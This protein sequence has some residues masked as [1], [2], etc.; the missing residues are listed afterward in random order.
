MTPAL[1]HLLGGVLRDDYIARRVR[2]TVLSKTLNRM[3]TIRH[4]IL[5]EQILLYGSPDS[6]VF[7][8]TPMTVN[9]YPEKGWVKHTKTSEDWRFIGGVRL[10]PWVAEKDSYLK[11]RRGEQKR[12]ISTTGKTWAKHAKREKGVKR[13]RIRVYRRCDRFCF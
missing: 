9:I 1:P 12:R 2:R 8:H 7:C 6:D 3:T 10:Q 11:V 4:V 5:Q 13:F